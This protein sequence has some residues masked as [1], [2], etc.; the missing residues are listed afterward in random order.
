[1]ADLNS[2]SP[3][4]PKPIRLKYLAGVENLN[5]QEIATILKTI[6]FWVYDFYNQAAGDTRVNGKFRVAGFA[7]EEFDLSTSADIAASVPDQNG[8]IPDFNSEPYLF[9][10]DLVHFV[11]QTYR[12]VPNQFGLTLEQINQLNR[13]KSLFEIFQVTPSSKDEIEIKD[14]LR[15]EDFNMRQHIIRRIDEVVDILELEEEFAEAEVEETEKTSQPTSGGRGGGILPFPFGADRTAQDTSAGRDGDTPPPQQQPDESRRRPDQQ[16]PPQQPQAAGQPLKLSEL[17]PQAKLYLQSLSIITINQALSRYFNDASLTQMGLSPGT[18]VT[19]DQLPLDIRQ[20]LMDRAFAQVETLILSGEFSLDRFVQDT[21]ARVNFA[22]KSALGL[23]IDIRGMGLL[24]RAVSQLVEDKDAVAFKQE[25]DKNQRQELKGEQLGGR[26]KNQINVVD[27]RS[28]EEVFERGRNDADFARLVESQLGVAGSEEQLDKMLSQHLDETI[29]NLHP[30]IRERILQNVKSLTDVYIQQGLPPEYL[31]ADPQKIDWQRLKNFF[32]TDLTPKQIKDNR[33][34]LANIIVFY[35]KRKRAIW[36]KEIRA[37]FAQEKLTPEEA[38]NLAA[39]HGKPLTS[40]QLYMRQLNKNFGSKTVAQALA[41][42]TSDA[43]KNNPELAGFLKQEQDLIG[44]QLET[45][46]AK[47]EAPEQQAVLKTY[48]EFY[49]PGYVTAEYSIEVFSQQIVPQISPLDEFLIWGNQVLGERA[50]APSQNRY[51][52]PT[53]ATQGDGLLQQAFTQ[54]PGGMS[55]DDLV[56]NRFTREA[57]KWGIRATAGA[58]TAGASEAAFASWEAAKAA[59]A[60]GTLRFLE[61]EVLSQIIEFIK[62]YWPYILFALLMATLGPLI[63]ALMAALAAGAMIYKGLGGA[64][65]ISSLNKEL[66]SRGGAAENL[67]LSGHEAFN[68]FAPNSTAI[69]AAQTIPPAQSLVSQIATPAMVIAGQTVVIASGT[70]FLL[71]YFYRANLNSAFLTNFPLSESEIINTVEKTSKYAEVKKTAKITKGCLLAENDGSKCDKPSFPLS[72]EYTITIAPK[73]DFDLQIINISDETTFKQS[74]SG[75]EK[76]GRAPPIIPSQRNLEFEYF[77]KIIDEQGGASSP[78]LSASPT[79]LPTEGD[80][81]SAQVSPAATGGEIVILAGNSL[82]FTYTLDGLSSDYN[83]TAI[84]NAIEVNFYYQ[85]A[86]Q[87]GADNV[88]TTARVCLGECSGDAGCWPMTGTVSQL[89]YDGNF[90]HGPNPKNPY[91]HDAYDIGTSLGP[92]L[93]GNPVFTPYDGQLCHVNCSNSGFGCYFTLTFNGDG[94]QQKL[95]FAHFQDPNPSISSPGSC[96]QVEAGYLIGLS[97]NRGFSSGNHLHYGAAHGGVFSLLN[98]PGP[99]IIETV[100]PEDNNGR[101]PP[102]EGSGV[103]TCYE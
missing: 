12:P 26:T 17:D 86:F 72:I 81:P 43:V 69:P 46:L 25:L 30:E 29:Q 52:D 23:L 103:T 3:A 59:D 14:L 94:G 31:I 99:S 28:A 37:E 24:N 18:R 70:I 7:A 49:M 71:G 41:D 84:S 95:I 73:E 82:T 75:W 35:W 53:Y 42:P 96:I 58:A 62:K 5:R 8:K 55:G 19:F 10:C 54:I 1:M 11:E 88:I 61:N 67:S 89:P 27:T 32:G 93:Y 15:M 34:A 22:N 76:A 9:M 79:P 39:K 64:R 65:E 47:M 101:H 36:A 4:K 98:H 63:A 16:Q 33:E 6:R 80:L 57:L 91:Y 13:L 2:S 77:R 74:R 85:N 102:V 90:S 40:K 45:E 51:L 78:P 20:Q 56:D 92:A 68:Q 50:F 97:G 100:V 60:T 87:Q 48:F 38:I 66:S 21:S 44:K 83:H